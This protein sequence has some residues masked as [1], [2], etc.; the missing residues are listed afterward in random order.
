MSIG[1]S[2]HSSIPVQFQQQPISTATP[3]HPTENTQSN[4][5]SGE[6]KNSESTSKS[7]SPTSPS[8]QLTREELASITQLKVRDQQVRTHE[9]THLATAGSLAQGGASFT[10]QT[11]PDGKRYATGG[12]VSVDTSTI[13]DD[14]KANIQKAQQIRRAALAPA[15]PSSADLQ[16]AA[17][18]TAMEQ[19]AL[20]ELSQTREE[21]SNID[22][23]NADAKNLP[24]AITCEICGG[25]HGSGA[26]SESMQK[27]L[28]HSFMTVA[29]LGTDKA[30]R[31]QEI[32]NFV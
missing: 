23:Q 5:H 16:A 7:S 25:S 4:H 9:Q 32:D 31:A 1:V 26:H 18:A 14:P 21:N 10:Y 30:S 13:S 28:E 2:N 17:K 19:Q 20:A 29:S 6:T 22:N 8:S 24:E 15:Q 12:E 3:S 27:R 11:G